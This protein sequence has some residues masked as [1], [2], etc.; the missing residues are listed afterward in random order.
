M[1]AS[2][3]RTARTA[4]AGLGPHVSHLRLSLLAPRPTTV[5]P[6]AVGAAQGMRGRRQGPLSRKVEVRVCSCSA[7]AWAS[8]HDF[9]HSSTCAHAP[10][11]RDRMELARRKFRRSRSPA[12]GAG[13]PRAAAHQRVEPLQRNHMGFAASLA[14]TMAHPIAHVDTSECVGEVF[15]ALPLARVSQRA[16]ACWMR[17]AV[18]REDTRDHHVAREEGAH[19][20]GARD[21]G[22][23]SWHVGA[24]S[25][26]LPSSCL[27][28]VMGATEQ[29]ALGCCCN[30]GDVAVV[31]G[32]IFRTHC[33][34]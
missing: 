32:A 20:R 12:V 34:G 28:V 33:E 30:V 9:A 19:R 11:R 13:G 29:Q 15:L 31:G 27:V 1:E 2:R 3:E 5:L 17:D 8:M 26:L 24:M 16:A 10:A 7:H 4:I 6:S 25:V 21:R 22:R 14:M 18:L 23:L